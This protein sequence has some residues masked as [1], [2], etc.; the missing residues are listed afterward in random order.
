MVLPEV[1]RSEVCAGLDRVSCRQGSRRSWNAA[2]C[3]RTVPELTPHP[4]QGAGLYTITAR[5]FMSKQ[6][7]ERRY[8]G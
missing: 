1:W 4:R 6:G 2:A 3:R 8:S 7:V 5:I